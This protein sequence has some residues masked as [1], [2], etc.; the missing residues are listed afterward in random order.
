MRIRNVGPDDLDLWHIEVNWHMVFGERRIHA[1]TPPFVEQSF[2]GEREAET[3]NN[4]TAE[5]RCN[6]GIDDAARIK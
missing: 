2:L 1:A 4:A 6:L 5:A 3:H